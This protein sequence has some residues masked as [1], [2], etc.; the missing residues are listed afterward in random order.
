MPKDYALQIR[1]RNNL[2]LTAIR[3]EGYPSV[4]AFCR[5]HDL[6]P[7]RVGEYIAL[8][9]APTALNGQWKSSFLKIATA[10]RRLPE[11]LVP[12]ANRE[13][14]LKKN[15]V[16]VE[17]SGQELV[18]VTAQLHLKALNPQKAM[19]RKELVDGLQQAL[20]CLSKRERQIIAERFGL[21]DGR[22][23]TL[24]E[25]GEKLG[26]SGTRIQQLEYRALRKLRHPERLDLFGG[27]KEL[28][29][30]LEIL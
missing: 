28:A 30:N 11:D 9:E 23:R 27:R 8:K 5:N 13:R 24:E 19:E 22:E 20:S 16:E 3:E 15:S 18:Q 26:V 21:E 1:V 25:I 4:L 29:E 7:S 10:L 2:L 14:A 6:H 12:K 17:V